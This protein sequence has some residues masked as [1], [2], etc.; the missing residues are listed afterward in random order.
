MTYDVSITALCPFIAMP[1]GQ[2]LPAVIP[3]VPLA[4]ERRH[5]M[6]DLRIPSLH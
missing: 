2:A 5:A 1:V 6:H 4:T 3:L